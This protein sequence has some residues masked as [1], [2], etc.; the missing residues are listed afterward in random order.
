MAV[1]HTAKGGSFA[2]S[3]DGKRLAAMLADDAGGGKGPTH[4][5]FLLNF[6]DEHCGARLPA[7]DVT[8]SR[9]KSQIILDAA[10]KP[11]I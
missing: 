11:R 9:G 1:S 7:N 4:L 2:P 6:F 5:T 8:R 10:P 3:P